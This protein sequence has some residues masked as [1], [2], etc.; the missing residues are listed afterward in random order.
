MTWS[1]LHSWMQQ[2]QNVSVIVLLEASVVV[3]GRREQEEEKYVFGQWDLFLLQ[4]L[5]VISTSFV[6]FSPEAPVSKSGPG[7]SGGPRIQRQEQVI[8]LSPKKGSQVGCYICYCVFVSTIRTQNIHFQSFFFFLGCSRTA[9]TLDT[10]A[11]TRYPA[12]LPVEATV[13][14]INGTKWV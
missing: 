3:C 1:A 5:W 4:N 8:H 11:V 14:V 7:Y 12:Q 9:L 10:P 13:T 6:S 2:R